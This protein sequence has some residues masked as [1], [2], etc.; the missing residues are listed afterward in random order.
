MSELL[1]EIQREESG[2]ISI[3]WCRSSR[4]IL[5]LTFENDTVRFSAA[6]GYGITSS[7]QWKLGEPL[8]QKF[9]D[10]YRKVVINEKEPS[11]VEILA[12]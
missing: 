12:G 4:S 1:P 2:E 3:E 5:V 11:V 8:P 9:I 6:T 10:A 7:A